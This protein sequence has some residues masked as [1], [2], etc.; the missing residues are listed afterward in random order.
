MKIVTN[1]EIIKQH[2]PLLCYIALN[3]TNNKNNAADLVQ[4]ACEK[5]L[6][7]PTP[8]HKNIQAW[9]STIIRNLFINDY[10]RNK[11]GTI[12]YIPEYTTPSIECQ[13][14]D[15]TILVEELLQVVIDLPKCLKTPLLLYMAGYSYKEIAKELNIPMNTVKSSIHRARA[16]IKTKIL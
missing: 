10:R 6:K 3:L 15:S 11:R 12:M 2:Y 4:D 8:H 13:Q 1:E 5:I 16:I 14:A 7:A 9:V